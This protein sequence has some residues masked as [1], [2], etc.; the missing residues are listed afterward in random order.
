M[1]RRTG[2]GEVTTRMFRAPATPAYPVLP[3]AVPLS[4][5]RRLLALESREAMALVREYFPRSPP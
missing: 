3:P 5:L 4:T 1:K 2:R